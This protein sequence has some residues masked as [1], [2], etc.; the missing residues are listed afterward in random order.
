[1]YE[2][3][4]LKNLVE[5]WKKINLEKVLKLLQ[6]WIIHHDKIDQKILY[7]GLYNIIKDEEGK[8]LKKLKKEIFQ[9]S[10]F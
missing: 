2:K 1:M 8:K 9:K 3:I 4:I 5:E 10:L 7:N 6:F